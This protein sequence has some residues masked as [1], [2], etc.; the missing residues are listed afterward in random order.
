MSWKNLK[1]KLRPPEPTVQEKV[2]NMLMQ[3]VQTLAMPAEIQE[4]I[5]RGWPVADEMAGNFNNW[6]QSLESELRKSS[7]DQFSYLERFD[8][9][10]DD[11]SGGKNAGLWTLVALKRHPCWEQVR[12]A[13]KEV[14]TAF[15]WKIE[16]PADPQ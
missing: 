11:M 16:P 6:Y 3:S 1:R 15:G 12:E 10:L 2:L 13:A 4:S 14:L 9:L 7:P 5:L 8:R